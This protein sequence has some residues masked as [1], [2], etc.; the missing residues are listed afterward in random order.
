MKR[1]ES[2]KLHRKS[3]V[4]GTRPLFK[5]R[6]RSSIFFEDGRMRC[7][8]HESTSPGEFYGFLYVALAGREI[9][10]HGAQ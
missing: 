10:L 3:G 2:T 4:W 1:P 6:G 7:R 8:C 5:D 9:D